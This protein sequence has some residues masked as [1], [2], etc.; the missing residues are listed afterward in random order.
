MNAA[1]LARSVAD[2]HEPRVPLPR[3]EPGETD[4][5][6]WGKS[7]ASVSTTRPAQGGGPLLAAPMPHMHC[8]QRFALP[9]RHADILSPWRARI[10]SDAAPPGSA[11]ARQA[12]SA[13]RHL[14]RSRRQLRGLLR[15]RRPHRALSVRTVRPARNRAL[16]VCREYTDEVWHGYL[17]DAAA[18]LLY[19]YRA[20]GPYEPAA[21]PPLQPQQAAAR[22]LCPRACRQ[23]ELVRRAV[24]LSACNRRAA[25]C[26]STGATARPP[27][28]KAWSTDDSF[29][30]GDDR[31]ARHPR[32]PTPSSTRRMSA[33]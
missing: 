24:R 1:R 2:E 23:P 10:L 16:L 14:G 29:N 13:G 30:W 5:G 31:S 7:S 25:T 8:S 6:G 19:G 11:A 20:H 4:R 22:S 21:R 18:G 26:R 9:R 15:P 17:P 32:G 3:L 12:L 27:C 33:A 28:R